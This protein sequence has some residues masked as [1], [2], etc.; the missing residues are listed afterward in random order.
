MEKKRLGIIPSHSNLCAILASVWPATILVQAV[1]KTFLFQNEWLDCR[2]QRDDEMS[3]RTIEGAMDKEMNEVSCE[4]NCNTPGEFLL[5][6][7]N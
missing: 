1:S 4:T 3:F 2:P 5:Y 7:L 6:L